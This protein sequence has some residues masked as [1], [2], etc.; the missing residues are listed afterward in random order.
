MAKTV[1]VNFID[2][3]TGETFATSEMPPESLPQTFEIATTLHLGDH[4][5][6]VEKAEPATSAEFQKSGF[7]VLT[8]RKI[9]RMAVEDLFYSQPTLTND[10]APLEDGTSQEDKYVLSFL[11][12]DWRQFEFVSKTFQAEIRAEFADIRKIWQ[13]K[14]VPSGDLYLFRELHIRARIPT[15]IAPGISLD[16]LFNAFPEKTALYEAI[17]YVQSDELV[18]DG[19]AFRVDDALNFYGLVPGGNVTVLGIALKNPYAEPEGTTIASLA[20]FMAENDLSLVYWPNLEQTGSDPEELAE[21][22][23]SLF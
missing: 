12:D 17:A 4:D 14:S 6:T 23:N 9:E 11:E 7:L 21:Y 16:R 10:L 20:N 15:P 13:E 18:K 2:A 19:F 3:V 22:F 1:R 5:W 8:L